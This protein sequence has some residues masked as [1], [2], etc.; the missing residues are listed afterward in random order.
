MQK[1]PINIEKI[2]AAFAKMHEDKKAVVAYMKGE[3]T[4]IDLKKRGIQL[5]KPI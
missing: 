4:Q 5:A 2:T 1:Q 3:I